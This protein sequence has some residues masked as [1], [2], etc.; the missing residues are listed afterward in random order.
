MSRTLPTTITD[1]FVKETP[2]IS[3]YAELTRSDG[4]VYRFAVFEVNWATSGAA[5]LGFTFTEPIVWAGSSTQTC[6]IAIPR[7]LSL[8]GLG[9]DIGELALANVIRNG[10]LKLWLRGGLDAELATAL[11]AN[12]LKPW[13]DGRIVGCDTA[14]DYVEI[15]ASTEYQAEGMTPNKR[16]ATPQFAYLPAAGA[17]RSYNGGYLQL[18]SEQ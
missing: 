1:E 6:K 8:S 5:T 16:I 13:F 10:V 7:S 9:A 14:P 2:A 12:K 18:G 17:T 3:Y 11:A 4:V 15:T